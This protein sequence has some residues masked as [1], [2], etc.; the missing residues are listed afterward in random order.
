VW[1]KLAEIG[2]AGVRIFGLGGCGHRHR[3]AADCAI[4]IEMWCPTCRLMRPVT[5]TWQEPNSWAT[6]D[7]RRARKTRGG[8]PSAVDLSVRRV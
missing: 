6:R 4:P 3:F 8:V 7:I 5:H 1:R 2:P